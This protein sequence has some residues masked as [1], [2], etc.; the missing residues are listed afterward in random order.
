MHTV[1]IHVLVCFA[2]F[3]LVGCMLVAFLLP[4]TSCV[5]FTK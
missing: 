5:L 3:V 1:F 4:C 2:L